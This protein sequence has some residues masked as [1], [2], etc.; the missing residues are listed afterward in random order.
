MPY[1]GRRALDQIADK[2]LAF[3]FLLFQSRNSFLLEAKSVMWN[4]LIP[5]RERMRPHSLSKALH[6]S[7]V[8]TAPPTVIT[9]SCVDLPLSSK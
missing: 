8:A 4:I 3:L 2:L 1:V 9:W 5:F 6:C 7:V